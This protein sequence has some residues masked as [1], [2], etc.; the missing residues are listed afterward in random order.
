MVAMDSAQRVTLPGNQCVHDKRISRKRANFSQNED[1]K[2]CCS[3]I[4]NG[5]R[6]SAIA[7]EDGDATYLC[8]NPI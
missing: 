2:L 4:H 5:D 8:V 6:D 7:K 3:N 1:V